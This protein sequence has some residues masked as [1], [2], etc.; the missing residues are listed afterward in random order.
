MLILEDSR[1]TVALRAAYAEFACTHNERGPAAGP[2]E[3]ALGAP[4]PDLKSYIEFSGK[5]ASLVSRELSQLRLLLIAI[6]KKHS[7]WIEQAWGPLSG[8]L[9]DLTDKV[10][11]PLLRMTAYPAGASGT[12]N[13]PHNDIDLF[14][15]LPASTQP[16]LE[17]EIDGRW[18]GVELTGN[19]LLFLPGDLIQ[20]FGGPD[21]VRH[22][23]TS[24]GSA[25]MSASMFVNADPLL[26][27]EET[28]IGAMVKE[29]LAKV[30]RRK[31]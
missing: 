31:L 10:D 28:S 3:T 18:R 5:G 27:V 20:H 16:G 17:I 26:M 25:R 13:H 4:Q 14:T 1:L 30:Q 2:D 11:G 12:V 21:P 24:N 19:Q 7:D 23:V 6:V 22:R 15:A 8:S 9:W 29:R